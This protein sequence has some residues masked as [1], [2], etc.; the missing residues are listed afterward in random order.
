MQTVDVAKA[1][2]DMA[3]ARVHLAGPDTMHFSCDLGISEAVRDKLDRE[4]EA[5]QIAGECGALP[6]VVGG[7]GAAPRF[8]WRLWPSDRDG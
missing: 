2:N 3:D 6:G 8:A 5:A 4:K 1:T 7:A